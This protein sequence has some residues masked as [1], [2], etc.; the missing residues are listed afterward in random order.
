VTVYYS[1]TVYGACDKTLQY[2]VDSQPHLSLRLL[3]V[4]VEWPISDKDLID[5]TNRAIASVKESG[6]KIRLAFLDAISS[7]PGVVVPWKELCSIFR[8]E[9]ILSLV[10]AAHSLGQEK[11][12][13]KTSQPDFWVSNAH[14]W[15]Y[16]HHSCAALYVAKQ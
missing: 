16:A 13:L 15:L 7:N 2:T 8:I 4:P 3:S 1:S 5:A 12:D 9:G 14:K 6:G 10:D 11:V